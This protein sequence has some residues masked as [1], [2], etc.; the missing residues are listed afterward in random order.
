MILLKKDAPYNGVQNSL[1]YMPEN[2][3]GEVNKLPSLTVPDQALDLKEIIR[4]FAAGIPMNVGK[5]PVFDE[6][7]DLPD[8]TKMDLA[9]REA[10]AE[11]YRQE[12]AELAGRLPKKQPDQPAGAKPPVSPDVPL[13]GEHIG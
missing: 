9:D 11:Q 13:K 1:N 3:P 10:Y 12:L 2:H 7:N 8:F 4:R 5:M 6:E